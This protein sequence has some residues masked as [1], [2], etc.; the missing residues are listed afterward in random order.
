MMIFLE[1]NKD[2]HDVWR[3]ILYAED[4][5]PTCNMNF[6]KTYYFLLMR[7]FCNKLLLKLLNF[8]LEMV[9]YGYLGF[10]ITFRMLFQ[11]TKKQSWAYSFS[12]LIL[13][14]ILD[15]VSSTFCLNE[16]NRNFI[17]E[18]IKIAIFLIICLTK[19]FATR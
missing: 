2:Y 15:I 18:L 17:Q 3:I 7:A 11:M 1:K 9:S 16:I 12:C 8:Y 6:W 19:Y 5:S 10:L 4:V 14:A 13:S